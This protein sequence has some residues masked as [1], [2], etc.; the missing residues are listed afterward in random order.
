MGALGNRLCKQAE[1]V[2]TRVAALV[3]FHT[4]LQ[5]TSTASF[6]VVSSVPP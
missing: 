2:T 1:I 5:Y 3:G 6:C 4:V